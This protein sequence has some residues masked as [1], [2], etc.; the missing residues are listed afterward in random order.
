MKP[1]H[2]AAA[3]LLSF[4]PVSVSLP[5][6]SQD[7]PLTLQARARFKEGVDAFD[8][9][10]YEEA[11]LS[12]LQAYTLKKHPAVLLNL[13]QSSAKSNHNVDALKYFQQFLKE[14]T[15]A[16]PQQKKDAETGLAEVRQKLGRIEV[17]AP[18][19]TEVSLDDQGKVGTTPMDPIDVEP[20]EHTVKSPTQSV[21]VIATVGQKV[22]AKLT[23]QSAA[24]PVIVPANPPPPETPP[25]PPPEHTQVDG[26]VRTKSS[27]NL[28]APPANMTPVWIGLGVGIAGFVGAG[29]FAWFRGDAQKN[30]DQVEGNIIDAAKQRGIPQKG[31]CNSATAKG[32]DDFTAACEQLRKNND[33]VD[34][35]ATWANVGIVTGVV[36]L[37]F[38][39]AWYL[40]APKRDAA[41]T[42]GRAPQKP[43]LV[44]YG[45]YGNGGLVLSGSF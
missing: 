26:A 23:P 35:N 25:P 34:T 39:G 22:Q 42:T 31:A 11:R 18:S 40:A 38:A 32:N 7:D 9:G 10:K 41:P 36:G 5:A 45:G 43:V 13:A 3:V 28:L 19:G 21:T 4:L 6:W 2:I 17:I 20:G 24:A 1:R 8:K 15:N 30:A 33:L 44:P 29:V 16:T 12:F 37:A 14:A 27:S